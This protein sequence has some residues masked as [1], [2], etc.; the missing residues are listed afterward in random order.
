MEP[1]HEER[2]REKIHFKFQNNSS[3]INGKVSWLFLFISFSSN[4]ILCNAN[5]NIFFATIISTEHPNETNS[6][7][8]DRGEMFKYRNFYH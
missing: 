6:Y 1:K 3:E 4:Y 8:Q 5:T 2:R 7:I